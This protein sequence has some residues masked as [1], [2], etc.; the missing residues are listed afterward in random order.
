ML[1]N[2]MKERFV[3]ARKAIIERDFSHLNDM[4]RAAVMTTEGPLLLL[5]GA[6]SGKT[7]VLINR[8]V[9]LIRYGRASDSD[10]VKAAVTEDDL[11]FLEAYA[12]APVPEDQARARALC[13]L[14]PVDPWRIIAITFTN[15]AAQELNDR[16]TAML[17]ESAEGIWAMTFHSA[18][19]RILRRD[20][21]RL[22]YER[23]FTIYDQDDSI[24]V[25]KRVL[26]ELDMDDR[27]FPPRSILG[28]ISRAKNDMLLPEDFAAE[29][30]KGYDFRRKQVAKA[31]T[32][33]A[34]RLRQANAA[35]FDD[36]I[37]LTVRL[38]K[39]YDDVR[40]HYQRLF[41]Y[42]LVDEYQDTDHL[43]YELAACLAGGRDNICV[44]G[45]DDQS[46]YKFRGATIENILSFEDQFK[47]ARTIRLEQNYRSTGHI[48]AAANAVIANN[49]ERKGKTLWT[50]NGQG[51]KLRLVVTYSDDEEAEY[52]AA[53]MIAGVAKGMHW[54]D[55]AVLYRM[56]AQAN[57]LEFAMKR[58]A[59]PYRVIGG[60][61]FFERAEIKDVLSYLCFIHNTEDDLRLARII[62][63][64]ARGIGGTTLT[65]LQAI[66]AAE[67]RSVYAVIEDCGAY[68]ELKTPAPRL[69]KFAELT[70]ELRILAAKEPLDVFY[71]A[72]LEKTHYIDSLGTND[73]A[74]SR[75]DNVRE[76]RSNIVSFMDRNPEPS[77]AAFL[78]EV[79]LYT[80]IDQ[81]A[82]GDD[83]CVLMT[84][85]SAKGL[86][87]PQVFIV[88]MEDGIF[89]SLRSI[90]EEE[91][92]EEERR[93]CYVAVTRA[94]RNLTLTA[95][96][97]RMLFGRTSS[98]MLSRFIDEIPDEHIDRPPDARQS[99]TGEYYEPDGDYL[100]YRRRESWS[101][102]SRDVSRPAR[103]FSG[104][105]P[106]E[107]SRTAG[108]YSRPAKKSPAPAKRPVSASPDVNLPSFAVGD[109]I[110]H[111]A[112]GFGV[113]DKITPMPSDAL[114][115]V[116]FD[117][118]G[119]KRLM[120]R[121]AAQYM[122]KA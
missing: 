65:K 86:E 38:L 78:D 1:D 115:E 63:V 59:I 30:E 23:S 104:E 107:L 41:R 49:T 102:R 121:S 109:R 100:E 51:E 6:G 83:C 17:G 103:T 53:Q 81:Y 40:E 74:L 79:A 33:Y 48:L 122:K 67:G 113:I 43:Q 28:E 98:N 73:E 26:K 57:R 64:P 44:V 39:E 114:I 35:D 20:I 96:K 92:M 34:R 3:K 108:F 119:K 7:T 58:N 14:D 47:N 5:A 82:P 46:I 89:P 8:I 88:G 75:A 60:T 72:L 80:D 11:R 68:P 105:Y 91:E 55:F 95:A 19:V 97:R 22:G 93:L 37:L 2:E 18:C 61:R 66:A 31:Y 4:Q 10:E 27:T 21:D 87:F 84:M 9:N 15:K 42:V 112:F 85:H 36:L 13:A 94:K 111:T 29:A 16:L 76:L 62:N 101:E 90:G 50:A 71:D 70:E 52:V 99:R 56:N 45:D 77:L 106:P 120:L 117:G 116:T 12:A 54:R 24:A 32:A 25:M 69:K 110:E 118:V